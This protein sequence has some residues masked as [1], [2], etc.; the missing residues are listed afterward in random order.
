MA[1]FPSIVC[2]GFLTENIVKNNMQILK[3]CDIDITNDANAVVDGSFKVKVMDGKEVAGEA[4][5]TLP[6]NGSERNST[7]SGICAS[8]PAA[9]K[10]YT[11]VFEPHN[12]FAIEL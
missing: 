12:L 9:E 7:L 8:L 2:N 3:P 5:F 6:Y 10:E 4:Y 11:F 1:K